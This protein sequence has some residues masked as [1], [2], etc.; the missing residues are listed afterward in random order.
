MEQ[1]HGG[2]RAAGAR[3]DAYLRHKVGEATQSEPLL[4]PIR[5]MASEC[6]VSLVTMWRAVERM[7][8]TGMVTS[9]DGGGRLLVRGAGVVRVVPAGAAPPLTLPPRTS[10]GYRAVKARLLR[11]VVSRVFPSGELLPPQKELAHRYGC[12]GATLSKAVRELV[13]E[14][15][16]RP[17]NRRLQ[18]VAA[19]SRRGGGVLVLLCAASR[20]TKLLHETPWANDIWRSLEH[21]CL[22]HDM[23]LEVRD[24]FDV[25]TRSRTFDELLWSVGGT[26]LG[27]CV[28]TMTL[29]QAEVSQTVAAARSSSLPVSLL[30]DNGLAALE[31]FA[32][33]GG[34]L[35]FFRATVSSQSGRDVGHHL[36]RLRHRRV[37][38]FGS[39]L[40]PAGRDSR[41]VGLCE[42]YADAGL[43][44]AVSPY[45]LALG[46]MCDEAF[47]QLL[48]HLPEYRHLHEVLKAYRSALGRDFLARYSMSLRRDEYFPAIQHYLSRQFDPLMEKALDDPAITVWVAYNDYIAMVAH[49]FLQRAQVVVPE[50]LSLVSFDDTVEAMASGIASYDFNLRG[51]VCEMVEH[52]LRWPSKAPGR[53]RATGLVELPGFLLQRRSLGVA[54]KASQNKATGK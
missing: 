24:V 7:K 25:I 15:V 1:S 40:L 19:S 10:F 21:E 14:G 38:Y 44:H 36:L 53:H 6:G 3:A 52:L 29:T 35:R 37:A 8:G 27:C 12:A 16:L 9:P 49:T 28:Y 39:G 31:R 22:R 23:R 5:G 30:D 4:P 32:D 17:E 54:R 26:P 2:A 34:R 13:N 50:R 48:D 46:T 33:A 43:A 20:L 47:D 51:V 41:Y 42:T 11:D 45:S 18:V